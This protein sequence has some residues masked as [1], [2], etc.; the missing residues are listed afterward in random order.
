MEGK[1]RDG[2]K[3]I[4]LG[5]GVSGCVVANELSKRG[6]ETVIVEKNS[7]LGGGCHTFIWGGASLYGRAKAIIHNG[8]KGI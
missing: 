7:Y 2:M 8:W 5:G 1:G 3:A 6:I 4:I